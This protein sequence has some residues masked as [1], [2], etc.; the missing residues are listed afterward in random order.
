[1]ARAPG[2]ITATGGTEIPAAVASPLVGLDPTT[3]TIAEPADGAS[4]PGDRAKAKKLNNKG[5]KKYRAGNTQDALDFYLD[6]IEA[7]PSYHWGY[8]NAACMYAVLGEVDLVIEHLADFKRLT[9]KPEKFLK[10]VTKDKDFA[11]LRQNP[12]FAAWLARQ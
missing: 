9:P 2:N 3:G 5:L 8:Y 6:S 4:A 11:D 1:M 10:K 12:R 7:D